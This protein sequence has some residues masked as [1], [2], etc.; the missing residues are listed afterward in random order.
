MLDGQLALRKA[1]LVENV[2]RVLSEGIFA[3]DNAV[4]M[5]NVGFDGAFDGAVELHP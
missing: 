4:G 3:A 5:R 1:Q 2:E